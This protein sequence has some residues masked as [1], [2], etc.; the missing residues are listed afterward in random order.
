MTSDPSAN[1]E[2]LRNAFE[3]REAIYVKRGALRV[4]VTNI[5]A[6]AAVQAISA[7]IEEI[8]TTGFPG[9]VDLARSRSARKGWEVR[10]AI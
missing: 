6:N 4:R 9:F 5:R 10:R 8:P 7:D 1:C 2:R 3:N